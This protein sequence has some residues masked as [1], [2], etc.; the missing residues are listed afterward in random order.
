MNRTIF[1]LLIILLITNCSLDNKS[2]IWTKNKKIEVERKL[3]INELF[4]EEQSI[5]KEFNPNLK[6]QL[7]SNFYNNSFINNL[8]NNNG[9]IKYNGNLTNISR[10]KYST[11]DNF[12]E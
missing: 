9:R 7:G 8:S 4:K 5:N 10:F 1:L 12:E 11:I 6:I 2:G 3:I